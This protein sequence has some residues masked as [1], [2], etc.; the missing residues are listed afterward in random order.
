MHTTYAGKL[1]FSQYS[2]YFT[3]G[4]TAAFNIHNLRRRKQLLLTPFDIQVHWDIRIMS[5]IIQLVTGSAGICIHVCWA[6]KIPAFSATQVHSAPPSNMYLLSQLSFGFTP[7]GW[8]S[9]SHLF[10]WEKPLFLSGD[11]T[12]ILPM[13]EEHKWRAVDHFQKYWDST[14]LRKKNAIV[15]PQIQWLDVHRGVFYERKS[16]GLWN[17]S[18]NE[19]GWRQLSTAS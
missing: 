2:K 10:G 7:T 3:K 14:H 9:Q 18:V 16:Y 15:V 17:S 1:L 19:P 11:W 12:C 6:S 4:F 8:H 13:K 5:K